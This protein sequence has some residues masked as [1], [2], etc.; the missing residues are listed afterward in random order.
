MEILFKKNK[1]RNVTITIFCIYTLLIFLSTGEDSSY[2]TALFIS[3]YAG[4]VVAT[5]AY[6]SMKL[7]L[8]IINLIKRWFSLE[9]L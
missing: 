7:V 6:I 3:I 1:L 9:L 5:I 4:L 2:I 8:Y